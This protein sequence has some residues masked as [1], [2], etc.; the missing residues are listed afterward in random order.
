ME[1]ADRERFAH[2]LRQQLAPLVDDN[3]AQLQRR[4]DLSARTCE[5][6]LRSDGGA[7]LGTILRLL[8]RGLLSGADLEAYATGR[9]PGTRSA[10]EGAAA[11]YDALIEE[12]VTAPEDRLRRL[13]VQEAD[14]A[15]RRDAI[16]ARLAFAPGHVEAMERAF[17]WRTLEM[18][19]HDQ[20]DPDT[21][22]AFPLQPYT[23]F[24]PGHAAA[25]MTIDWGTDLKAAGKLKRGRAARGEGK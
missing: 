9:K 18:R 23:T 10:R 21:V 16:R 2:W 4:T 13:R 7:D 5:R 20:Q 3:A 11:L 19:V 24:G 22:P 14:P 6:L 15:K 1:G 12:V 8:E 25:P 17:F